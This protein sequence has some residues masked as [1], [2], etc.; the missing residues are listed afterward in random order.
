MILLYTRLFWRFCHVVTSIYFWLISWV[1]RSNLAI[2]ILSNKDCIS[3][4]NA[5]SLKVNS[6]C[7]KLYRTYSNRTLLICQMLA[8]LFWGLILKECIEVQ[9]KKKKVLVFCWRSPQNVNLGHI[10]TSQ[11]CSDSKEMYKKEWC[12]WKVAF[13]DLSLWVLLFYRSRCRYC[14]RR[15]CFSSLLFINV[16]LC[17]GRQ[18]DNY[19]V[20]K[21]VVVNSKRLYRSSGKEKQIRC[22]VLTFWQKT[23]T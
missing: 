21:K 23:W 8:N 17:K 4:E 1:R 9:E 2:A 13:C 16:L 5:T 20:W 22:L 3:Y 18:Q 7:F 15:C 14:R 19:F 6:I 10:F 11:S 12:A